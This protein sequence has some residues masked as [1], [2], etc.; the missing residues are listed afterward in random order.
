MLTAGHPG[1][2]VL[3][4]E[5]PT[6][7]GPTVRAGLRPT[8]TGSGPG[9]ALATLAVCLDLRSSGPT[10]LLPKPYIHLDASLA[11]SQ[12]LRHPVTLGVLGLATQAS[13]GCC[14]KELDDGGLWSK[15]V[16]PG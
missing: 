6:T 5:V 14:F 7:H 2:W 16:E 15:W 12:A 11:N 9:L 13:W 10:P 1:T 3:W 8:C 4:N